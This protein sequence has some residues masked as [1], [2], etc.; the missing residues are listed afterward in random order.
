MTSPSPATI[1]RDQ[2]IIAEMAE[3]IDLV[4]KNLGYPVGMGLP[5]NPE[6]TRRLAAELLKT[7]R[8]AK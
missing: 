6:T 4:I 2:L 1:E 3:L 8:D 7:V 5:P